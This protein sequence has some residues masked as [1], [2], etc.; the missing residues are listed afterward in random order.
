MNPVKV[1]GLCDPGFGPLR[2]AFEANFSERGEIGAAIALVVD[3]KL[4]VD[5]WG[6]STDGGGTHHWQAD[7][8]VNIWST[9][10]GVTATCFAMLV[11]RGQ[12][13]Y[14][15]PVAHYWPEFGVAG[16]EQVTVAMMLSHQ[17][18][19]CGFDSPASMADLYDLGSAAARL[20]AMEPLWEPGTQSGYHAITVG[21]LASELFRRVE[22]RSIREFVADELSAFDLSIG[23][24]ADRTARAATMIA[25]P[26]LSSAPAMPELSQV[27]IAALANPVMDP[28]VP[29]T[30]EWRAAQIPSANGFAHARGLA[31][32]YGA[33][34]TGNS[35]V[36]SA[37]T[38]AEATRVRIEGPDAVL[39]LAA[40]WASGFLRNILGL[41]GTNESAFGH[42]GWG[43]SFAF[44]DPDRK[45]GFAYTPNRMG[46]DLVGDPR[47][48]ALV[49]ALE[50]CLRNER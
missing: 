25:P 12:I 9:T 43:G 26:S 2:E 41:Y 31:Q 27:Q 14:D 32:L 34:A 11:D 16:K 10:K 38:V 5:L 39:G 48:V 37:E 19:L 30:A 29:N 18:G 4:A 50:T 47:S 17:A 45:L 36:A 21:F 40:R 8:L 49:A 15:K 28:T 3:G 46:S 42:S 1:S 24:P 13:E 44:A 33:L 7:T 22:G 6:G 23:L 20:A 35:L